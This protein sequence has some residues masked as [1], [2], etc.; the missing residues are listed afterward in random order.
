V[1]N[2]TE[3]LHNWNWSTRAIDD[4]QVSKYS[5]FGDISVIYRALK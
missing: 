3:F 1:E 5:K 2:F 4:P